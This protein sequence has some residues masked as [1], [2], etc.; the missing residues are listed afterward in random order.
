MQTS[1]V[2]TTRATLFASV[3][4]IAL[5]IAS[6]AVR[7]ADLP[8]KA[9]LIKPAPVLQDRW[10]W[11]VEGGAFNTSDPAAGPFPFLATPVG[12]TPKLGFEGAIGFDYT[13]PALAPY[14][15]SGQF[16]YGASERK[17]K[18]FPATIFVPSPP[19]FVF[20]SRTTT[21]FATGTGSADIKQHHWLVDFAAGRDFQL[22][23]GQVQAKL[24][25]RVA[26]IYSKITG[27][28]TVS[29]S[30]TTPPAVGSPITGVFSFTSRS[31]F[32]GIGP[33]VGIEGA[34]PLSGAWSL[35]YLGGMAVLFGKRSYD[36]SSVI[37][38]TLNPGSPGGGG[39]GTLTTA[40]SISDTGAIFNL[41][42]QAGVSYWF[43]PNFKMTA[44]YRFD[45]Y[46]NALKTVNTAGTIVNENVFYYGP[47][48]RATMKFGP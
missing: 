48:L 6:P 24:G 22:G 47:M 28:G 25:I 19:G 45:G 9:P 2:R 33:R 41:D 40:T 4:V 20:A 26:D 5:M 13:S 31:R 38:L 43:N 7:A 46:W 18:T 21:A 32:L 39:S 34:I 17:G 42:G 36:S 23:S 27:S 37:T 8:T 35:D 29:G 1:V 11:W 15:I 10:T 12:I 14:H 44:S 16:R 3:S 30:D